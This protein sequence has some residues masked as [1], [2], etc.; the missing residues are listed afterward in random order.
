MKYTQ[1]DSQCWWLADK[2]DKDPHD[3]LIPYIERLK[4][5]QAGR[6]ENMRRLIA[7]YERGS[8]HRYRDDIDESVLTDKTLSF[9]HARNAVDTV[10]C[11]W[12]KNNV[13]PMVLT[14][15]GGALERERAK[16][17]EKAVLGELRK[18]RWEEIE[19][20][21]SRDALVCSIGWAHVLHGQDSLTIDWVP[22]EDVL[23]DPAETRQ[24]KLPRFM[25]RRF[26]M[27]KYV[28]IDRW[29]VSDPSFYGKTSQR[30]QKIRKCKEAKTGDTVRDQQGNIIEVWAAFHLG[31][32]PDAED[33][34]YAVVIDG[35]TMEFSEWN[36]D[37]IPL[38][39]L[40]AF[41]RM[42]G[43]HGLS[44]MADL[45]PVQEEHDK[46]S[47]R[48]Q[49]AH[50]FLGGTHLI[51]LRDANVDTRDL[52]NAQGTII[53]A[54]A[55]AG[56]EPV[57]QFNPTPVN[58][59][60]YQYR[61]GLISEMYASRGIPTMTATGQ[62]PDG[63]GGA[64]GKAFQ[65]QEDQTAERMLIP[66]RSQKRFVIGV[67]WGVVEEARAMVEH[68]P[69][70]SVKFKGERRTLEKIEWKKVLMDRDE[71]D[72]EVQAVSG[73]SKSGT[74]RFKQL[75]LMLSN[76]SITPEQFRRLF[77][78]PDLE[79]EN[80]VDLADIEIIDKVMD[81]IV[82]EGKPL[83]PEAFDYLELIV[84][85]GRK[86]YNLC[87]KKGVPED[88]L[89]YLRDYL[90]RAKQMNDEQKAKMQA[91]VPM[92]QQMPGGPVGPITQPGAPAPAPP[93]VAA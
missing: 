27:D 20:N 43:L 26:L 56:P 39:P 55:T 36:R 69:K 51:A 92:A 48:I 22:G 9:N 5:N 34:A 65:E 88:R 38:F 3:L 21:A 41:P 84:Q 47:Q 6:F 67:T 93:P 91:Q 70:Y 59:Q 8:K 35:A 11:K 82:I 12:I 37:Y 53:E 76:G 32:G 72:L 4:S 18:N 54:D 63:M 45:L 74:E 58:P 31:S 17:M 64:S 28:A 87:R 40:V 42:R 52:N 81:Q 60:T 25:A 77:G 7:A 30:V 10:H 33:G 90:V 14:N 23:F 57:R 24:K 89:A 75:S 83:Q 79:A 44:L 15:G 1:E 80:E 68:D 49:K 85:R 62:V 2:F 50:H 13:L 19:E 16:N 86:F 66:F 29:G 46:L 71:F 78:M 61:E 73:L